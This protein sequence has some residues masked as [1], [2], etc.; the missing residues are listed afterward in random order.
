MEP[1]V[2]SLL[3][4][5]GPLGIMTLLSM[6][7]AVTL[8]RDGKAE[9]VRHKAEMDTMVERHVAKAETWMQQYNDLAKSMSAVLE[10]MS[11]RY[12]AERS[13]PDHRRDDVR[14]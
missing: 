11:K 3:L 2:A 4:V 9:Q 8:Y 5:Y 13:G 7:V 6:I 14:R 12:G 1:G 10:S